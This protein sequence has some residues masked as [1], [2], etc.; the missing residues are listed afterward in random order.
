[1]FRY[2]HSAIAILLITAF[3]SISIA[4]NQVKI[5]SLQQ[6]LEKENNSLHKVDIYLALSEEYLPINNRSLEY[7]HS[8]N[9]IANKLFNPKTLA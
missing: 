8:A 2:I 4:Q 5:D 7:A 6:S 1:M 3:S 9:E